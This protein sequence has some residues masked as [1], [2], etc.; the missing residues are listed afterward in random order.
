MIGY[1]ACGENARVAK[2]AIK[3]SVEKENKTETVRKREKYFLVVS[4]QVLL[5][6]FAVKFGKQ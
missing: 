2:R 5:G 3:T 1:L 6:S 4:K